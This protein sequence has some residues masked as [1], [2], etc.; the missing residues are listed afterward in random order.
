MKRFLFLLG[1]VAAA[2]LAK[3]FCYKKT[4]GFAHYKI[5]SSL[6]FNEEWEVPP[7]SENEAKEVSAILDQPFYYLA[8]GAQS[9]VFAS[10]DGQSVIKFFRIYHLTPPRWL[11]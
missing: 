8:K 10:K 11:N 2:V 7:L 3:Q 5:L 1:V 6:P 4:D 9:Y